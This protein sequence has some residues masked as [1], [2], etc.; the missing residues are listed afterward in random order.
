[1]LGKRRSLWTGLDIRTKV[2]RGTP[3]WAL[4][5]KLG[6]VHAGGHAIAL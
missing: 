1:V 6:P 5:F 3:Q 4:D 2:W